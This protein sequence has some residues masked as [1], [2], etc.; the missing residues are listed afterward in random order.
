M[1][2]IYKLVM[3]ILKRSNLHM[4]RTNAYTCVGLLVAGAFGAYDL[5]ANNIG[6][7][8]RVSIPSPP[9]TDFR[10]GDLFTLTSIQQLLLV[11][12]LAIAV[13]G[14]TYSKRVMMS[15]QRH[16]SIV[17]NGRMGRRRI[18]LYR[19]VFVRIILT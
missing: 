1:I 12:A 3:T 8:A 4:L 16:D 18:S 5:G 2:V 7:V 13:G 17:S 6:N 9:F 14:T 19:P 15:R 11:G 10:F